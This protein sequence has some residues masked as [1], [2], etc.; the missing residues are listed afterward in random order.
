MQKLETVMPQILSKTADQMKQSRSFT[1]SK[2]DN[3]MTVAPKLASQVETIRNGS[4]LI[5][6]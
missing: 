1:G 6:V 3:V 4:A 2:C 5:N